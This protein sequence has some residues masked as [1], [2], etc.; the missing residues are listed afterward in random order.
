V[1]KQDEAMRESRS[2]KRYFIGL[3]VGYHLKD[4]G[5]E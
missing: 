4:K 1:A 5:N 3:V 2:R